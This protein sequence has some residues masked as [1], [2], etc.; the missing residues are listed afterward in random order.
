MRAPSSIVF[1]F[2]PNDTL[3][4]LEYFSSSSVSASDSESWNHVELE[5]GEEQ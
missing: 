4:F 1:I 3:D 2:R 5:T